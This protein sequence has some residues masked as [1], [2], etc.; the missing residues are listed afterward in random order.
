MKFQVFPRKFQAFPNF[1]LVGFVR[2]QGLMARKKE[3][4]PPPNFRAGVPSKACAQPGRQGGTATSITARCFKTD[5]MMLLPVSFPRKRE[6]SGQGRIGHQ[7]WIPAFAGMTSLA[8][9]SSCIM[10]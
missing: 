7:V 10:L 2:F 4:C 8:I 9:P 6:S 3:F 1:F 5:P